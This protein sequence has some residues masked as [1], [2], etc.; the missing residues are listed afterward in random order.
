MHHTCSFPLP[1]LLIIYYMLGPLLMTKV[2]IWSLF[3]TSKN[4][5]QKEEQNGFKVFYKVLWI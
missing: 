1:R 2:E 4:S 5:A 3:P